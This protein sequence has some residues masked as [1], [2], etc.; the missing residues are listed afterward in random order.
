VSKE[1]KEIREIL[2]DLPQSKR[3]FRINSGTGWVSN[4]KKWVKGNLILKKPRPLQ[5]GPEGWPDLCG[6]EEIEITPDMVGKKVAVFVFEEV[7]MTGDLSDEQE[8]FGRLLERMGGIFRVHK[9][10]GVSRP[11]KSSQ[12][13]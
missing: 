11:F 4:V 1:G 2:K 12:T 6:W 10:A 5:A 7:K 8:G 13:T 3:L 9:P